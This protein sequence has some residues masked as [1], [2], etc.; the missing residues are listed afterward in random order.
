MLGDADMVSRG[1]NRNRGGKANFT[2]SEREPTEPMQRRRGNLVSGSRIQ[3]L[4]LL[5]LIMTTCGQAQTAPPASDP[6]VALFPH[7]QAARYWISGQDN[8]IFQWHP[9]LAARYSGT[10]SFRANAEHATSNVATLFLGLKATRTTEL[11]L[12]VETA[13]GGGVS[14]ALGLAGFV[15]VDVVRN[16]QLGPAPY[17]ARVMVRQIIPLSTETVAADRGP[18]ALAT[19][20]PVRRLELRAGK[21]GMADFFD[22]NGVGSDR[23]DQFLN[24]TVD[25]N[26]AY[27]YAPTPGATRSALWPNITTAT[28]R[29]VSPSP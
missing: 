23:H 24:W 2:G 4:V 1:T 5:A 17:L 14:D 25:N 13:D 21:F 26:G 16:P 6:A 8:I 9:S 19:R 7:S 15:N 27:D 29:F 10:N 12:D 3:A 28:G 18:L 22:L 11:F 20:L